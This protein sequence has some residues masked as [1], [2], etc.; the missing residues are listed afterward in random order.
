[1]LF[2][3]VDNTFAIKSLSLLND[4]LSAR[5]GNATV[6]DVVRNTS[7]QLEYESMTAKA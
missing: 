6:R 3:Q 1:M 7:D 5:M 4:V 2:N